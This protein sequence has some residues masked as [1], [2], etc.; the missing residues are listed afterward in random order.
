MSYHLD[1]L[2]TRSQDAR[3]AALSKALPALIT[4]AKNHSA[5]YQ[6]KLA[7]IDPSSL[8]DLG[9]IANLP[10]TR[11]SE[12]LQDTGTALRLNGVLTASLGQADHI[13]Q[14]PALSMKLV[15]AMGIGG[16]LAAR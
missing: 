2:E 12:L 14:S 3:C 13:F 4:H 16:A 7:D 5:L 1:A 11:K 6:E 9:A 8:K 15:C 10:V